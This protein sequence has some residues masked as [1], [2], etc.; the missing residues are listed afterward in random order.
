MVDRTLSGR[1]E[2]AGADG[3]RGGWVV[4]T[5]TGVSVVADIAVVLDG[6]VA[7]L[8]IDMP[9]GL[10]DRP[11][12]A[13]DMAARRFLGPRRSSIFSTPPRDIVHHTSYAE[14]N[15]ATRD[16]HSIGLSVQA[17]NLFP[18]IRQLDHVVRA[19]DP[20]TRD[21]R[22]FEV[23]PECS[24]RQ[25]TG[26]VLPPKR[27]PEGLAVR[28]EA[29][30][31]LFGALAATPTGAARDD[32]LDAYAVLWSTERYARGEHITLPSEEIDV[33]RDAHGIAMRIVV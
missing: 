28:T 2:C 16:L 20:R 30:T 11:G 3:C 6:P 17:F 22:L 4:A 7:H 24:F 23:H 10:P 32:V 25:M 1:L 13:S 9:M 8:G 26:E 31:E 27:T 15:A 5:R 29:V 18:K 33:E 14:A 12:R 19:L 21:S